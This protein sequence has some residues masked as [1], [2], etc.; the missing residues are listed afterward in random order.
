M[1]RWRQTTEMPVNFV[2]LVPQAMM[3]GFMKLT[4][5]VRSGGFSE[6]VLVGG[7]GGRGCSPAAT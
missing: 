1:R 4:R 6:T 5:W 2:F 7:P 3:K